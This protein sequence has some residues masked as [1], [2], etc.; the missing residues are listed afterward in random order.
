MASGIERELC[1]GDFESLSDKA[2]GNGTFGSVYKVRNKMTKQIFAIKVINKENI[3]K[4]NM[5]EQIKKEIE[6]IYKLDHPN[7]I[8]LYSH[9][10][11]EVDFCLIME[12]AS[13]G[14]LF[15]A[16]KKHKKFNQITAKQYMQ[17]I[18]SAVKYL[19]TNNPPIIHRDIKPENILID[20]NGNCKL[21]DFGWACFDDE[22]DN[23]EICCG[24]PEYLA[25]EIINRTGH[26]KSVDIWALGILLFEMLS[27]RTPFNLN[28]SMLQ[29][30][31]SIQIL[32]INWP[33]DFPYLAKDLI[34]KILCINPYARLNLDEIINHKW[35]IKTPSL[36]PTISYS[37]KSNLILHILPTSHKNTKIDKQAKEEKIEYNKNRL[38]IKLI[39]NDENSFKQ[40]NLDQKINQN[41]FNTFNQ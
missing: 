36:R 12:Y 38:F 30:Y 40:S 20:H 27:G 5:L 1:K 6:I 24:T 14:N 17:E 8:K 16:L 33:D 13:K 4:Q 35:F 3:M 15:S 41:T 28:E 11:D 31:N 22:S 39:K 25:P 34:R 10:E 23:R 2:I 7:I 29:L 19:H 18:I 32:N 37:E 26:G 9:F 21:A